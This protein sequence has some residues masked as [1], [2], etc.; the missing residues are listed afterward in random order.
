MKEYFP[1]G[2]WGLFLLSGCGAAAPAPSP[3]AALSAD[4]LTFSSQFEG[5]TSRAQSLN[6]SNTGSATLSIASIA[7][8]GDFAETNTC[9]SPLAPGANCVISV[10]FSPGTATG[11]LTGT[12]SVTDNAAGS[13]QTVALSGAGTSGTLSGGCVDPI[14]SLGTCSL[15]LGRAIGS[16]CPAGQQPKKLEGVGCRGPDYYDADSSCLFQIASSKVEHLGWCE[17]TP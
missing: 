3:T 14:I 9:T 7:A 16:A 5:T 15:E 11:D 6:L 12:L 1:L 10:A 2:L 17:V 8:T 4:T 13:P